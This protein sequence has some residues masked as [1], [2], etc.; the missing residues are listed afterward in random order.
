MQTKVQERCQRSSKSHPDDIQGDRP[1]PSAG[2]GNE[3][4]RPGPPIQLAESDEY[5]VE[6]LGEDEVDEIGSR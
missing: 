2:E 6:N 4:F 1:S 5:Q 3:W